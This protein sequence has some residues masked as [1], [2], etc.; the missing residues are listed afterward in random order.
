MISGLE[1]DVPTIIMTIIVI[2]FVLICSDRLVF[3]LQSICQAY[4]YIAGS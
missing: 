2:I 4:I 1:T 3:L